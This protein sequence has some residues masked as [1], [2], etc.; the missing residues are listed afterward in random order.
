MI[1]AAIVPELASTFPD[2]KPEN[3]F[4]ENGQRSIA[5]V[6]QTGAGL[7]SGIALLLGADGGA[8]LMKSNWVEN[9]QV[10]ISSY[11]LQRRQ[12][13]CRPSARCSWRY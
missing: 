7:A 4:T 5:A 12:G 9:E 6:E 10:K 8:G 3:I 2:F 11:D 1:G 13:N